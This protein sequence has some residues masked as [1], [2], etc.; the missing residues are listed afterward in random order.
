MY[1]AKILQPVIIDIVSITNSKE[2]K[3][4]FR[5]GDIVIDILPMTIRSINSITN[6]ISKLQV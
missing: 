2:Q 3:L 6:L 1:V 5:I 4:N